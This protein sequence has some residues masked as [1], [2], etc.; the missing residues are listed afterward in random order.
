MRGIEGM[1]GLLAIVL[2]I[3][4][5]TRFV[6]PAVPALRP[7]ASGAQRA[8]L[9]E[10]LATAAVLIVAVPLVWL[11]DTW[12][13]RPAALGSLALPVL[14]LAL[15]ALTVIAATLAPTL[16]LARVLA[17]AS[18]LGAA[19]LATV[20]PQGA[21]G[22]AAWAAVAGAA[23]WAALAGGAFAL[24]TELFAALEERLDHDEL[25]VALRGIAIALVSAGIFALA[26][27][28]LDG[29]SRG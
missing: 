4:L 10:S 27:G 24:F 26:L 29:L 11:L 28:G 16:A 25:P 9:R 6:L 8:R 7:F 1:N 19:L 17:S 20:A 14:I 5:I 15:S 3:V 13:L 23:A 18:A 12:M 2:A 21:L 22:A